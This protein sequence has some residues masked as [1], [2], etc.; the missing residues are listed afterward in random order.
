L[1]GLFQEEDFM[2]HQFRC[3]MELLMEKKHMLYVI[4]EDIVT[5]ERSSLKKFEIYQNGKRIGFVK[6]FKNVKWEG[7]TRVLDT[8]MD[9]SIS[10][11]VLLKYKKDSEFFKKL[12]HVL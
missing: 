3:G 1:I 10:E 6:D 8:W 5:L 7:E 11:L 9:S 12:I 2:Q 4:L